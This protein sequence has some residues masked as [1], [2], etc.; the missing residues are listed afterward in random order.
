MMRIT[1]SV[2]GDDALRAVQALRNALTG[3]EAEG[4]ARA[5]GESAR[6][7]ASRY[8]VAFDAAGGWKGRRHLGDHPRSGEFGARVAR[9]WF[10]GDVTRDTATII[11]N[12]EHYAFKVSGGVITPKRA[13]ALTIPLVKEAAGIYA[14]DY[15]RITGRKLFT[16]RG[17]SA[18]FERIGGEITG[19]RGRG[20][21]GAGATRIRTTNIRAVY[22]LVRS[23]TQ[24]PWPNA[25]PDEETIADAFLDRY[26]DAL[27]EL[28]E[29]S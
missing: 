10:L 13:K 25:I 15:V 21:G 23:V 17:K 11:N 14:R 27:F 24:R 18:L 1:V 12:A 5:G 26:K 19:E 2:E 9:G 29:E 3:A 7:A 22:A 28:I 8:H 6:D 20:R 4:L 16:I